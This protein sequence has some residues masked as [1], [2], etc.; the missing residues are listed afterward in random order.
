MEY[1]KGKVAVHAIISGL[2]AVFLSI[3][4]AS[5]TIAENYTGR[6]FPSPGYL[7]IGLIW[8][9]GAAFLFRGNR[10]L[11]VRLMWSA[12]PVGYIAGLLLSA[13]E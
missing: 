3:F 5:G 9:V 8:I 12:I 7:L 2:I 4:F 10:K 11:A 6:T 1:G 13:F